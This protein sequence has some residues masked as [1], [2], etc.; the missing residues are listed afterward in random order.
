LGEMKFHETYNDDTRNAAQMASLYKELNRQ[1]RPLQEMGALQG[2]FRFMIAYAS[3][4]L[5]ETSEAVNDLKR[6]GRTFTIIKASPRF[7]IFRN[8]HHPTIHPQYAQLG[9]EQQHV[10][11]LDIANDLLTV[12]PRTEEA[13]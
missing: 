11:D 9:L 8:G 6:H 1:F 12:I 10:D 5:A 13:V 2:D 3:P 4:V 7:L